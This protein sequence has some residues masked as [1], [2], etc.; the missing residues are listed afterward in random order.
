MLQERSSHH[1]EIQE[2]LKLKTPTDFALVN[3]EKSRGGLV[4]IQ[5]NLTARWKIISCVL[6]GNVLK[7][8]HRSVNGIIPKAK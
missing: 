5:A 4:L 3:S 1:D 2:V 8:R 6:T 7:I